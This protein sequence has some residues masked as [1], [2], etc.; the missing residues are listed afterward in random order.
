MMVA[1]A[2]IITGDGDGKGWMDLRSVLEGESTSPG[3]WLNISV[4][5]REMSG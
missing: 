3:D 2:S 1:R 4:W 5:E